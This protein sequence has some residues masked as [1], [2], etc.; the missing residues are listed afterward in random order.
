MGKGQWSA[1]GGRGV[2]EGAGVKLLPA[3]M[4]GTGRGHSSSCPM[5]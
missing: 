4:L 2:G 1:R 5:L 3:V